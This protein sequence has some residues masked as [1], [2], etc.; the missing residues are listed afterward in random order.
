MFEYVGIEPV[1]LEIGEVTAASDVIHIT[2]RVI[3]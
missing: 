3:K 1:D 2:Y